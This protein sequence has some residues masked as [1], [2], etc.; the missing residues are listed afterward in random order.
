MNLYQN[1]EEYAKKTNITVEQAEKRCTYY[2]K[3]LELFNTKKLCPK[4]KQRTLEYHSNSL[5]GCADTIICKYL[6]CDFICKY[7]NEFAP[8]LFEYDLDIILL[9]SKE[10]KEI[11]VDEVEQRLGYKW[12]DF[13][14]KINNEDEVSYRRNFQ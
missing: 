8:L 4:C 11:G 6:E 12:Y 5:E 2:T 14:E 13:V 9:L 3:S 1:P 7:T 10:I